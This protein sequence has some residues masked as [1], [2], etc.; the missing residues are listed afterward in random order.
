M[1]FKRMSSITFPLKQIVIYLLRSI[2]EWKLLRCLKYLGYFY[3]IGKLCAAAAEMLVTRCPKRKIAGLATEIARIL[4]QKEELA[5]AATW[6][7]CV[8]KS[9]DKELRTATARTIIP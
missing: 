9:W 1:M 4:V 6:M 8:G 3:N 5:S 7:A 2:K